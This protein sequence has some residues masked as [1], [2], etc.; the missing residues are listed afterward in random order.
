[1]LTSTTLMVTGGTVANQTTQSYLKRAI[2]NNVVLIAHPDLSERYLDLLSHLLHN[3]EVATIN[4]SDPKYVVPEPL[5]SRLKNVSGV[6]KVDSRFIFE[7]EV[8]EVP[9]IYVEDRRY[10]QVGDRRSGEALIVGVDPENVVNE[11][12]VSGRV[13]D[14]DDLYSALVGDSLASQILTVPSEQKL[15]IFGKTFEVAGLILDPLNEGI[16]VY[17]PSSILSEVIGPAKSNL[18]LLRL[19]QLRG[20]ETME[21]I[22]KAISGSMLD[23]VELDGAVERYVALFDSLWSSVMILSILF[24]AAATICLFG[25]MMLCLHEQLQE[26]GIMRALGAK[27]SLVLKIVSAQVLLIV[28]SSAAIGIPIGFFAA[29]SLLLPDPTVSLGNVVQILAWLFLALVVLCL[30]GLYP[31]F[32]A[33]NKSI[34]N[35]MSHPS[36]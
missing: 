7:T 14:E 20:P 23:V 27:P 15:R 11:W 19:D 6:V 1:M 26:I 4:Y 13:L 2:G 30:S 35:T 17:I 3:K 21:D 8:H 5:V 31:V 33:V 29:F 9:F 36:N 25:Y 12:L 22:V 16:V 18:L 10:F 24:L 28:S 34:I 32:K